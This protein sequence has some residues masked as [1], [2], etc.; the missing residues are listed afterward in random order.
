MT[1]ELEPVTPGE[2]NA[3][4][5]CDILARQGNAFEKLRVVHF[6]LHDREKAKAA[7]QL[8]EAQVRFAEKLKR[9]GRSHER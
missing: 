2:V 6:L 4:E 9:G 3:C 7:A 8:N 1:D 5:R